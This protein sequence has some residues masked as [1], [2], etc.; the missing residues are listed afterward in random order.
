[1]TG[2]TTSS[3]NEVPK[4]KIV[5][6]GKF[7]ATPW[8]ILMDQSGPGNPSKEALEALCNLYWK[9][10]HQYCIFKGMKADVAEDAV[11]GFLC[12]FISAKNLNKIS[13]ERGKLR[14]YL[15]VS[16][17]NFLAMD[18]RAKTSQQRGGAIPHDSLDADEETRPVVETSE[19][20]SPDRVFVR[21]WA[22][23]TIAIA[24]SKV[25]N[26]YKLQGKAELFDK[27]SPHVIGEGVPY[28][29][30]AIDLEM[31]VSNLKITVHRMKKRVIKAMR[32][33]I[34]A[35]VRDESE[36]DGELDELMNAL[37]G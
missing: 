13:E 22:L 19:R 18:Y 29:E 7:P 9:P 33:T 4:G 34:A 25:E 24:L 8:T 31:S 12:H 36:V 2:A 3:S 32:E 20:E 6:G 14:S 10:L 23:E 15:L 26:D 35:T 1:M 37:R 27:V 28:K 17:R 11:Q 30:V 5:D 21:N 16:L